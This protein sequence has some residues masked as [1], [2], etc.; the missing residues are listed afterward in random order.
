MTS[1]FDTPGYF[2]GTLYYAGVGDQLKSFAVVNGRL[3]QT[4]QSPYGFAY[5]AQAP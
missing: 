3:K 4:G 2:Q 1:S 5:P